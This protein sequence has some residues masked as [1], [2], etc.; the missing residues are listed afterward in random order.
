MSAADPAADS[1]ERDWEQQSRN[2]ITWARRPGFDSFWRY[3][4]EF[5]G[6]VPAAGQATLDLGCG[7]GR[8]SREL[9]ARGHAV[10]GVDASPTLLAAA[11]EAD[12]EGRY[13]IADAARI[14][15]GDG[16]FDLIVSYNVLMDV[17]DVA[18]AIREAARVLTPG[19]RFV[20]AILHPLTNAGQPL[21]DNPGAPFVLDGDYFAE[22]RVSFEEEGDGLRMV[23]SGWD[24][25]LSAYTRPLEEAGLLIEA[26]REPVNVRRDGT[27]PSRPYH[28]WLRA[29]RPAW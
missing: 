26:V 18:G 5:F 28:F 21:N 4:D 23:F 17:T 22:R 7:E 13:L 9:T 29:L 16:E 12:P 15:L 11:R 3:A 6:F 8:V 27:T 19:G 14:P 1:T 2:W 20:I 24:R 10:T 25:P